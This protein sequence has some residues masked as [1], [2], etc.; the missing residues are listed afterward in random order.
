MKPCYA[1]RNKR[2]PISST[3]EALLGNIPGMVIIEEQLCFWTIPDRQLHDE[4][5]HKMSLLKVNI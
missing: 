2:L 4:S 1:E 5:C 3:L